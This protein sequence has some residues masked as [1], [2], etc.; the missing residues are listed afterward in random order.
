MIKIH[1]A[2][3]NI[4]QGRQVCANNS[5]GGFISQI[6]ILGV[7]MII[8]EAQW[9]LESCVFVFRQIRIRS[10]VFRWMYSSLS[11]TKKCWLLSWTP[12]S[13]LWWRCDDFWE[14]NYSPCSRTNMTLVVYLKCCQLQMHDFNLRSW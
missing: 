13:I 12:W 7:H 6:Y 9:R 8:Q 14:S 11:Q 2:L 10:L 3:T 4:A 5:I 1:T